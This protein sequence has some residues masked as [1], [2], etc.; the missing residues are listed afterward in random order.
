MPT[1]RTQRIVIKWRTIAGSNPSP[2]GKIG[3]W[4]KW[5]YADQGRHTEEGRFLSNFKD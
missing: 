4:W 3:V 5:W 1:L 2:G